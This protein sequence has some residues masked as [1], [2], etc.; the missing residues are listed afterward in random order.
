MRM[1][2]VILGLLLISAMAAPAV[3]AADEA[4]SLPPYTGNGPVEKL[5]RGLSNILGGWLEIPW[6]IDQRYSEQ[7]TAAS[8]IS[9]VIY[10]SLYAVGRTALGAYETVTFFLPIPPDYVST[11][12]PVPYFQKSPRRRPLLWE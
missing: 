2:R 11:L 10:G 5:S 3:Q 9:G 12:P 8:I 6:N 1:P 7:N 4:Q